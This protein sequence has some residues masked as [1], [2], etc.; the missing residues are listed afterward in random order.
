MDPVSGAVKEFDVAISKPDYP[1]GVLALRNDREGKL[2]IGN[3]Y[4]A[5]IARFDP[6][7]EQFQFFTPTKGASPGHAACRIGAWNFRLGFI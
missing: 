2:W 6:V 4:Q 3:M 7:T 5:S 1:T